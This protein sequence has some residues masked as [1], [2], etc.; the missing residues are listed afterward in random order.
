ML[1]VENAK[2]GNLTEQ[3]CLPDDESLASQ[4]NYHDMI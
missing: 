2:F 1:H 4:L 3:Q